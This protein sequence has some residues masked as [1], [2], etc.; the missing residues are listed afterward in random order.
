[1]RTHTEKQEEILRLQ[2]RKRRQKQ[3]ER[4][5]RLL[6]MGIIMFSVLLLTAAGVVAAGKI[7]E[8]RE[9]ELQQTA[10]SETETEQTVQTTQ[11]ER[12]RKPGPYPYHKPVEYSYTEA[13]EQLE[14]L[15]V[16]YPEFEE[17]CK[18]FE[19]YPGDLMVALANNPDMLSF[20]E[21]Y[22][23]ADQ[24]VSS[25]LTAAEKTQKIPHLLQW[26]KRWGYM[27]YGD[28]N[29]ALSGCAP[30]CLSMVIIGLTGETQITPDAVGKYAMDNSYY[31]FGTGTNWEL[32]TAG[33][34]DFGIQ[35]EIIQPT[36]AAVA[37]AL[38]AGKP[39][40]CSM[41]P[42]DFT[43][44]GHFIVLTDM[45]DGKVRVNDPN[46][47][48]RSERMWDFETIQTQIKGLWA[49]TKV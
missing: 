43:Y 38:Q 49:F 23:T 32:M 2:E 11:T 18:N 12:V 24:E 13:L 46:S 34:L 5:V 19:K 25:T 21:G 39:V 20:V 9:T 4:D 45:E 37:E 42:G 8:V 48:V 36:E 10:M 3:R 27:S 33:C 26:D 30:T 15:A 17:I 47:K 7:R 6:W 35:G 1:M 41:G 28:D 31:V 29:M 14:T 40:I 22:L 44:G 16:D